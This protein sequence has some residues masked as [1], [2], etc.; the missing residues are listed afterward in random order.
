[1]W[2]P[3]DQAQCLKFLKKFW[4]AC[5]N[6]GSGEDDRAYIFLQAYNNT[7]LI[8]L[9]LATFLCNKAKNQLEKSLGLLKRR[10]LQRHFLAK[11]IYIHLFGVG[12]RKICTKS[13]E[14][15]ANRLIAKMNEILINQ[16]YLEAGN[17]FSNPNYCQKDIF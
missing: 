11:K 17:T 5:T 1:M 16:S 12:V 15:S 9:V 4:C 14:L 8:I 7:H 3:K 10:F 2:C 13:I 6:E